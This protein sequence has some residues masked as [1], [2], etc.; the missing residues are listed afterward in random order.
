[1]LTFELGDKTTIEDPDFFG[2]DTKEEVVIVEM[3]N[4]LDRPEQNSMRVQTYKNQF[5]DLF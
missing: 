1:L 4:N 5:Q 2:T 3:I